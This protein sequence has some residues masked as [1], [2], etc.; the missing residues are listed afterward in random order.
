MT[1]GGLQL[2]SRD[3]L[4]FA[5]LYLNGGTWNGQRILSQE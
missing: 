3:L 4:K 5:Q 1:G 2:R